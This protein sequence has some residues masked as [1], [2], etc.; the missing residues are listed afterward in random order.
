M[1]AP[2]VCLWLFAGLVVAIIA[3]PVP[4]LCV[5]GG[6]AATWLM[7]RGWRRANRTIAD[8]PLPERSNVLPL[9]RRMSATVTVIKQ[10]GGTS[11]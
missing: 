1:T 4:C 8:A 10:R 2:L 6:I 9:E 11:A 3:A 7:V 5:L